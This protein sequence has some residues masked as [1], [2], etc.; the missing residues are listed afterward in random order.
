MGTKYRN[1]LRNQ[2]GV[3]DRDD[4]INAGKYLVN[5]RR[6]DARGVCIMGS[7]AGGYLLLSTILHSD[8]IKAAA[9]LYGVSDLVG[10]YK[11]CALCFISD[12]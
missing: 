2:W 12:F 8:I 10:L 4:M 1:L 3:V 6:V 7:S 5:N 9:S 11:V